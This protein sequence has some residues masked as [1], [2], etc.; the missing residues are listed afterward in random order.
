MT[1]NTLAAEMVT[2]RTTMGR[3]VH[4]LQRDGLITAVTDQTNWRCKTLVL[5]DAGLA[6]LTACYPCWNDA[7]AQFHAAF[8]PEPAA[9]LRRLLHA[10]STSDIERT[11]EA[12]R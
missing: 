3:N 12:T 7:Q 8:G 2:G 1:V 9:E 11:P 10:V 5:T 4:P 6:R